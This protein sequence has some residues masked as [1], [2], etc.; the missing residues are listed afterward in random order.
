[1]TR[2]LHQIIPMSFCSPY[3]SHLWLRIESSRTQASLVIWLGFD[4]SIMRRALTSIQPTRKLAKSELVSKRELETKQ[5]QK[6]LLT[7]ENIKLLI[8]SIGRLACPIEVVRDKA[9]ILVGFSG[10]FRRSELVAI[11]L[12]TSSLTSLAFWYLLPSQRPTERCREYS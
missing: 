10:A 3:S 11:D 2:S 9:I 12:D 5:N 7:T 4:T 1:M 8:D 6:L